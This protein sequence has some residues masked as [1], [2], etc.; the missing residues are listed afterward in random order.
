LLRA[1]DLALLRF[2]RVHGH[3]RP[4]EQAVIAFSRLGEHS[5]LWLVVS[6]LGTALHPSRRGV[7]IRLAR[8]VA[9]VELANALAKLAI[10]RTRPRLEGLPA[11]MSTRS[12]RS[13]PSAHAATSFAA[14]RVLSELVAPAAV[15]TVA[16]AMALSRPYLGVHY[17]SDVLA[18]VALG[19]AIAKLDRGR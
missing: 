13:C 10:G 9:K 19:T 5:M 7:Y 16:S 11:L 12:N 6:G 4:F 1:I 14:A 8:T 18:G 2:L 17:P 15:Y 3:W